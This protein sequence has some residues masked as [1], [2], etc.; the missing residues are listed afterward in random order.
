M[1]NVLNHWSAFCEVL[2]GRN[3]DLATLNS[4]IESHIF[5]LLRNRRQ[6][7][8]IQVITSVLIFVTWSTPSKHFTTSPQQ[9]AQFSPKKNNA[10]KDRIKLR[11]GL[12]CST[13]VAVRFANNVT[14]P[15]PYFW[16]RVFTCSECCVPFHFSIDIVCCP[17]AVW[18]MYMVQS[19]SIIFAKR[20]EKF[21][22]SF[23]PRTQ[24]D[25]SISNE[26]VTST[27][28]WVKENA[29]IGCNGSNYPKNNK[30]ELVA[31]C[32]CLFACIV[33][34]FGCLRRHQHFCS[35]PFLRLCFSWKSKSPTKLSANS[36]ANWGD[37]GYNFF[38]WAANRKELSIK[39][40]KTQTT[41][42]EYRQIIKRRH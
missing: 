19:I 24:K 6:S 34:G 36:N 12:Q 10:Q 18:S 38:V 5:R 7:N 1:N 9:A 37:A 39:N 3:N 31:A 32:F 17:C 13:A 23:L 11:S 28:N 15:M 2:T 20:M 41:R 35:I 4:Q 40:P 8:M 26:P 33:F 22:F 25:C 27:L 30:S 29:A 16:Y 21:S 14:N 42:I